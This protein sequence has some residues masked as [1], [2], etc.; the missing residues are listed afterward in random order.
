MRN[1]DKLYKMILN[2]YI[3]LYS[4][5]YICFQTDLNLYVSPGVGLDS[6]RKPT[7]PMR[8]AAAAAGTYGDG[9]TCIQ[10]YIQIYVH[11]IVYIYIYIYIYSKKE[12]QTFTRATRV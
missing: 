9:T 5:E 6:G 7:P 3:D 10:M 12:A 2:I 8:P 11:D 4:K 1:M